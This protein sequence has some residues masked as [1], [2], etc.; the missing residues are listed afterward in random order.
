MATTGRPHRIGITRIDELLCTGCKLCVDSCMMDVIYFNDD[1][2]KAVTRYPDDCQACFL[3][4]QDCPVDAI[5]IA[6][7]P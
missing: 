7:T 5:T 4:V 1:K 2:E 6:A 3:C